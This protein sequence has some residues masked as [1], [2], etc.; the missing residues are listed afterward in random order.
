[1]LSV[2]S[3]GQ[4][5]KHR[6][7]LSD[8]EDLQRVSGLAISP[9]GQRV[10]YSS[11]SKLCLASVK[12]LKPPDQVEIG[13]M[14]SWSPDS[15]SLAYY[16]EQDGSTRLWLMDIDQRKTQA[17]SGL[18]EVDTSVAPV[19]S[20]DG[21]ELLITVRT[22]SQQIS[23]A[24]T[25]GTAP[26]VVGPESSPLLAITG[27][28]PAS[29][30]L[31]EASAYLPGRSQVFAIASTGKDV[32]KISR[33]DE[34]A[35]DPAWSPDGGTI[36]F[37]SRVNREASQLVRVDRA[38]AKREVLAR[39]SANL[40]SPRWSPDGREIAFLDFAKRYGRESS[41]FVASSAAGHATYNL[42]E[43]LD[44]NVE[45]VEWLP[46]GHALVAI[47]RD[48]VNEPVETL[49]LDGNFESVSSGVAARR[50]LAVARSGSLAWVQSDAEHL[51]RIFVHSTGSHDDRT[52]ADPNPQTAAWDLGSQQVLRWHN[53]RGEELEGILVLP[54][55][56]KSGQ[57][58]PLI[59]DPYSNRVNGFMGVPIGANQYLAAQGYALFFPNH[60]AFF[61]FPKSLKGEEYARVAQGQDSDDVMAD[62]VLSG[63]QTV[64]RMGIADPR[65]LALFGFSTGASAVDALLTKTTQFE[66][67]ISAGGV[68]DWLHYYLLRPP[69]DDT[70]PGMLEGR[71]PW[72]AP[73]LYRKLSPI[74][75]ADRIH[76]PLLLVIG[77]KDTRLLDSVLFYNALRRVGRPVTL[78]R[79]PDAEHELW[80]DS[81][82]DF[83]SR[84]LLFLK[85]HGI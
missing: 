3:F 38:G 20:P 82:E 55:Q 75:Q 13:V 66:A 17:A 69:D 85:E 9:D 50:T 1:M 60:R 71:T 16:A 25:E 58:V 49:S 29:E 5:A 37:V 54:P 46:G 79:Y 80:G 14:P 39:G 45:S 62:D 24:H 81:L 26:L 70:I 48:G 12:T 65:G 73:D 47:I 53:S 18:S 10:A 2:V 28:L 78:V 77:D 35:T 84:C 44:R 72:D 56:Y 57:K 36:A 11:A 8:L 41:V 76:T 43:R 27:V 6:V 32:R 4:S 19:W 42:T 63:V 83:W 64:V 21:T 74:Y 7:T 61:T 15:R 67:A 31:G 52:V 40:S 34:D 33:N 68:A 23:T 51:D 30:L 59:V 22:K